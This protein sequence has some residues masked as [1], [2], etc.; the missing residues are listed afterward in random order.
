MIRSVGPILFCDQ[1][2]GVVSRRLGS[3]NEHFHANAVRSG[4][5][6][7]EAVLW[8]LMAGLGLALVGRLVLRRFRWTK[9][10]RSGIGLDLTDEELTVWW[11]AAVPAERDEPARLVDSIE[12]FC[13]HLERLASRGQGA[14]VRKL[15]RAWLQCP[16]GKAA[17]LQ[18]ET[19][20]GDLVTVRDP[21]GRLL[22]DGCVLSHSESEL[23]LVVTDEGAGWPDHP[24]D[25]KAYVEKPGSTPIK[26]RLRA[27]SGDHLWILTVGI[28]AELGHRR[29]DYRV[30]AENAVLLFESS[31]RLIGVRDLVIGRDQGDHFLIAE[32][33]KKTPPRYCV[34]FEKK[35]WWPLGKSAMLEDLSMKGVRVRVAAPPEPLRPGRWFMLYLSC[36]VDGR[37]LELLLPSVPL[38]D[39]ESIPEA[40]SPSWRIRFR[41]EG[42]VSSEEGQ[43]R[44]LMT[45][46]AAKEADAN[47]TT[48]ESILPNLDPVEPDVAK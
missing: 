17:R 2:A 29:E 22:A 3:L 43:L 10:L 14:L 25:D 39:W 28:E 37:H 24:E 12:R 47:R 46:L 6:W 13:H 42:L 38:S 5:N 4:F 32:Q 36:R 23:R 16:N 8:T 9:Q 19:G 15:H 21:Q 18:R 48:V 41:F 20:V 45:R 31:A 1:E 44:M 40:E 30:R 26:T 27:Q 35:H 11:K 34:E 33:L 7:S